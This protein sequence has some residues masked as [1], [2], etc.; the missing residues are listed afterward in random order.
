MANI[1]KDRD[2]RIL[3][4][5]ID[6]AKSDGFQFLTRDGVAAA[7]GVAPSSVNNAFGTMRDLKRAVLRH[8]VATGIVEIVAQGLADKHP[9]A[10]EASAELKQR[11]ASFVAA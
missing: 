2:T 11:A 9:I 8:A 1:L 7:A 10:L 4:A 5:A 3:N 6:L